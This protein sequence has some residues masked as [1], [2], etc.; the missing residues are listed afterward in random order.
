MC[1]GGALE[2]AARSREH[3]RVRVRSFTY[4]AVLQLTG[5]FSGKNKARLNPGSYIKDDRRV[6]ALH[7]L[8]S[9]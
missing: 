3:V 9:Q 1:C 6:V 8:T 7:P 2:H 5:D 4:P